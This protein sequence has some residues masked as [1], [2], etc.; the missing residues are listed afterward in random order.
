MRAARR[1]RIDTL[2]AGPA[3][4]LETLASCRLLVIAGLDDPPGA[5]PPR[6]L[7]RIVAMVRAARALGVPVAVRRSA[8]RS[9]PRRLTRG[10]AAQVLR[11]AAL[12]YEDEGELSRALPQLV[13]RAAT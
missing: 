2:P 12:V 1:G 7:A 11:R 10:L 4:F 13:E 6:E 9:S 3:A 5:P 8:L